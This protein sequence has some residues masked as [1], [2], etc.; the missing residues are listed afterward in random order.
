ML[1]L[2]MLLHVSVCVCV[3][4]R[5]KARFLLEAGHVAAVRVVAASGGMGRR[6]TSLRGGT[7]RG[8]R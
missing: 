3:C 8:I 1:W 7:G 2:C 5:E 6:A 4:D